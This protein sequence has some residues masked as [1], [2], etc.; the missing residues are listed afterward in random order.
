MAAAS[1]RKGAPANF[2]LGP[3]WR[4][5]G[6]LAPLYWGWGVL[7]SLVLAAAVAVPVLRGWAGAGWATGGGLILLAYTAWILVSVWRSADNIERPAPLGID[8]AAWSMLARVLTIGWAIN[9]VGLVIMLAQY[10]M[11]PALNR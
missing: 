10:A 11:F 9:A 2:D 6:R 8:R 1:E 7:A 3:W 5:E 4:G